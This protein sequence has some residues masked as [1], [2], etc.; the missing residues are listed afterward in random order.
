MDNE[1]ILKHFERDGQL[2]ELVYVSD[3]TLFKGLS[4]DER[5]AL[6]SKIDTLAQKI[7]STVQDDIAALSFD[8]CQNPVQF[9]AQPLL[10]NLD[11]KITK[12]LQETKFLHIKDVMQKSASAH[13]ATSPAGA[14]LVIE[15]LDFSQKSFEEFATFI[16]EVF[17]KDQAGLVAYRDKDYSDKFIQLASFIN[18][19]PAIKPTAQQ[20]LGSY[21]SQFLSNPI[22]LI[23]LKPSQWQAFLELFSKTLQVEPTP[24]EALKALHPYLS[25]NPKILE[26]FHLF[27]DEQ[28]LDK[29]LNELFEDPL[30]SL[31]GTLKA[32]P[33]HMGFYKG[34]L[35]SKSPTIHSHI[36]FLNDL[37]IFLSHPPRFPNPQGTWKYDYSIGNPAERTQNLEQIPEPN[38]KLG[39][40][41]TDTVPIIRQKIAAISSELEHILS[42]DKCL[43][44]KVGTQDPQNIDSV[45]NLKQILDECLE[46]ADLIKRFKI[47]SAIK[48]SVDQF[49]KDE[50]L[51]NPDSPSHKLLTNLNISLKIKENQDFT[52]KTAAS[53]LIYT[54]THAYKETLNV[55]S[56]IASIEDTIT[57]Q[58]LESLT[59]I[60]AFSPMGLGL[61]LD[62]LNHKPLATE[63]KLVGD[64]V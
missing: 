23:E 6:S 5:T 4:A 36:R 47:L 35:F 44:V 28:M 20:Q 22:N 11:L 8:H 24:D 10:N 55:F 37:S 50:R 60:D 27:S 38:I 39:I 12:F 16:G 29:L 3:N 54:D 64:L 34:F 59:E 13:E 40:V 41:A 18:R 33:G 2:Y 61:A 52:L 51:T 9:H 42:Q 62:N 31:Q 32:E 7:M 48:E 46:P 45:Q 63:K 25:S 43:S 53:F 58:K 57:W 21:F 14:A 49:K 26:N 17:L 56:L 1:I 30:K 15:P 19:S